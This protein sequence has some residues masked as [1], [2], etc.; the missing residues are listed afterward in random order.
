MLSQRFRRLFPF[1][2]V[3]LLARAA[4]AIPVAPPGYEWRYVARA[5]D[6]SRK[7]HFAIEY[8]K[9]HSPWRDDVVHMVP[10][11]YP[12][13]DRSAHRSGKGLYRLSL[14]VSTGA[15]TN[16][17]IV[18]STGSETLDQAAIE[19]LRQW[20]IRPEKWL[21]LDIP[22]EFRMSPPPLRR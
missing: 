6:T 7:A 18:R 10:P 2:L 3:V 12:Y 1:A 11:K 19:A 22:I 15:V 16:V 21:E 8:P 5:V 20:A 4:Y 17:R 14:D 9:E 13:A